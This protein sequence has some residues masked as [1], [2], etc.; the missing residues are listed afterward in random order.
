MASIDSL[1]LHLLNLV[2]DEYYYG[3]K[4]NLVS[5]VF[6]TGDLCHTIAH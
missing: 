3:V 4:F 1:N 6:E 5:L 2:K